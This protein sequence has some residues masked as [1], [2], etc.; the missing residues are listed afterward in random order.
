MLLLAAASCWLFA[1]SP[2]SQSYYGQVAPVQRTRGAVSGAVS[3]PML[4]NHSISDGRLADSTTALARRL[5]TVDTLL[6][7]AD[8][9]LRVERRRHAGILR[10][11]D[12]WG[13]EI[14]VLGI[15]GAHPFFS[16]RT[17]ATDLRMYE[18]GVLLY[19]GFRCDSC[20][21]Q[22]LT[23]RVTVQGSRI[24]AGY[25]LSVTD[26]TGG[27]ISFVEADITPNMAWVALGL[28]TVNND[29]P[30]RLVSGIWI[31]LQTIPLGFWLGRASLG[32][33]GI[34]FSGSVALLLTVGSQLVVPLWLGAH[35]GRWSDICS[36]IGGVLVGAIIAGVT[37]RGRFAVKTPDK[38]AELHR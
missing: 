28:S 1:L 37:G 33:R 26:S 11:A 16:A 25:R 22:L 24:G 29:I 20:P 23:E 27:V 17:R 35:P 4:N 10:I 14:A 8:L 21:D 36:L 9:S 18:P 32:R 12:A 30:T 2:T 15:V 3:N 6:L 13:E 31:L 34:L 38:K 19:K 5:M 7:A